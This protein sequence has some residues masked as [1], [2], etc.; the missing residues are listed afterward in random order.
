MRTIKQLLELMLKHQD[1]FE[2][3]L[4]EWSRNLSDKQII[5]I[6][7]RTIIWTYITKNKP[8][9]FSSWSA[10][11]EQTNHKR[12]GYYWK[13]KDITPRIKWINKHINLN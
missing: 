4:C 13:Y 1:L 6:D 9:K 10:Y 7:E 12:I 3:G 11:K 5:T 8:S 2:R